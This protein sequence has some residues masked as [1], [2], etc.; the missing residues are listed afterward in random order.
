MLL[1]VKQLDMYIRSAIVIGYFQV[2]DIGKYENFILVP[3]HV[4]Y[5]EYN[6]IYC[7]YILLILY[8]NNNLRR[9]HS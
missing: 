4:Y 3:Y 6:S 7:Y 9:I 2:S 1:S 5:Q 8:Y